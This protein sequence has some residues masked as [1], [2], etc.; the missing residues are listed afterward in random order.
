MVEK[1]TNLLTSGPMNTI[2]STAGQTWKIDEG[3]LLERIEKIKQERADM[4]R[5]QRKDP[6]PG[7]HVRFGAPG[8]YYW[9]YYG[10]GSYFCRRCLD[11]EKL[12]LEHDG[13][14]EV[15]PCACLE[16]KRTEADKRLLEG[17]LETAG[18]R[19]RFRGRS[20]EN[21]S[22]NSLNRP[23][24]EAAKAYAQDFGD[25]CQNGKSLFLVGD[26]GR[27]KTHL[28]AAVLGAVVR[29]GYTAAFVVTIE[30]L[31]DIR[32][33]FQSEHQ[34]EGQILQPLREVQLL[35]LDDISAQDQY[36]EWEKG[37]IFELINMRYEAQKPMIITSNKMAGWIKERLGK[38]VM[39]RLLEMCG[40]FIPVHGDNYREKIAFE[41]RSA[42]R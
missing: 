17:K 33:S 8:E 28:A 19:K 3:K 22:V 42:Q 21:F 9:R 15:T 23:A 38:K 41:A 12:Y 37:K 40:D 34:T 35:V 6:R 29:Q 36:S 2:V 5:G 39:D 31:S 14:V 10:P 7:H 4:Q 25:H 1:L 26:T 16:L 11:L 32:G 20:F 30:L 27:G 24:W 18:L 13:Q